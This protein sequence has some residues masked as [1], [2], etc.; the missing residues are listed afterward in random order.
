MTLRFA[1]TLST[2]ALVWRSKS[3][4]VRHSFVAFVPACSVSVLVNLH[5]APAVM[6]VRMHRPRRRGRGVHRPHGKPDVAPWLRRS[7]RQRVHPFGFRPSHVGPCSTFCSHVKFRSSVCRPLRDRNLS[8]LLLSRRRVLSCVV[9]ILGCRAQRFQKHTV[10]FVASRIHCSAET[11]AMLLQTY[12]W[13][14]QKALRAYA[15]DPKGACDLAGIDD[16]NRPRGDSLPPLRYVIWVCTL[17]CREATYLPHTC[18]W[19]VQCVGS[20][21]QPVFVR[22]IA[23]LLINGPSRCCPPP[24]PVDRRLCLP[25]AFASTRSRLR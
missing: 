2:S 5:F 1:M 23:A 24:P 21:V 11:A 19:G 7:L 4:S 15:E 20:H 10:Q 14:R 16:S 22:A 8:L 18:A 13:D 25:A 3:F 9:V 6:V 17:R 12:G